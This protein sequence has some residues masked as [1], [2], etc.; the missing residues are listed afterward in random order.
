[1]PAWERKLQHTCP[2]C[3]LAIEYQPQADPAILT[4]RCE[5]GHNGIVMGPYEERDKR[6]EPNFEEDAFEVI[7]TDE[8]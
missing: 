6:Y 3:G 8:D 7:F 5:C 2:F 1:M 4:F